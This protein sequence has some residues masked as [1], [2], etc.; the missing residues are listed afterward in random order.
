M[1]AM[2]R[3]TNERPRW[4]RVSRAAGLLGAGALLSCLVVGA[5]A[6]NEQV[7]ANEPAAD[8]RAFCAPLSGGQLDK[9]RAQGLNNTVGV[10]L[11]DEL[12]RRQSPPPPPTGNVSDGA[13]SIMVT[14]GIVS[15]V[16]MILVGS[17][18]H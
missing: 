15:G 2:K 10:I 14:R 1:C 4:R 8:C 5:A 17:T 12:Q 7:A 18:P 16:N 3:S 13:D 6:A 11:W 9:E